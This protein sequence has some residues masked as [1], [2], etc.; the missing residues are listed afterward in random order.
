MVSGFRIRGEYKMAKPAPRTGMQGTVKKVSVGAR[1]LDGALCLLF[2]WF[3]Y[4]TES[5]GW[6][7]FWVI[8]SMFCAY[9]AA[10]APLERLP[11]LVQRI[12]GVKKA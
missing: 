1:L 3:A 8:S 6:Q 7:I 4:T 2:A 10:T 12:M 9:T 11:A 5:T